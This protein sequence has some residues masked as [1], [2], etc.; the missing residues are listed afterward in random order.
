MKS[1]VGDVL[2]FGLDM[3]GF[4]INLDKCGYIGVFVVNNDVFFNEWWCFYCV[5]DMRWW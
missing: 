3:D 2:C 4:K 1:G 5:F